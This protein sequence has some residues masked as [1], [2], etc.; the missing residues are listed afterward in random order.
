MHRKINFEAKKK[1]YH[2]F[3]ANQNETMLCNV[4]VVLIV[5][6]HDEVLIVMDRTYC[7]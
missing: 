4:L 3:L 6:D 2:S 5:V 7:C 1:R